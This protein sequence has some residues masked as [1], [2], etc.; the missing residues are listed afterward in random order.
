MFAQ[1]QLN[2]APLLAFEGWLTLAKERA[3]TFREIRGPNARAKARSLGGKL[4]MQ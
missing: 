1:F 3:D 4:I 2:A